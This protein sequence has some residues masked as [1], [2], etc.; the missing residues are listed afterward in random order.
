MHS[1]VRFSVLG[2]VLGIVSMA[3]AA[4]PPVPTTP[5]PAPTPVTPDPNTIYIEQ[6]TLGGTG[7]LAGTVHTNLVT[8]TTD[9]AHPSGTIQFTFDAF[10]A[11]IGPG[12]TLSDRTKNCNVAVTLHIPSGI[13]V[14]Q[15][16][17]QYNGFAQ[18]DPGITGKQTTQYYFANPFGPTHYDTEVSNVPTDLDAN[19]NYSRNDQFV[20]AAW[21]WSTCGVDTIAN[22]NSRV[23]LSY[24]PHATADQR[25]NST[26]ILSLDTASFA[27]QQVFH[28]TWQQCH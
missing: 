3:G 19:G 10:E 12:T 11:L 26:G 8:D 6:V 28:F 16:G 2:A 27:A 9:P 18:V 1:L 24:E 21:V 20:Q 7:C 15:I 23:S 17:A 13:S 4:T 5:A 22:V 25:A 14:A